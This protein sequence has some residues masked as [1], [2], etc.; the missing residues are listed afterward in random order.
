MSQEPNPNIMHPSWF[1]K[2][3]AGFDSSM[4][5]AMAKVLG[6]VGFIWFCL[7]LDAVGF[8]AL[9]QQTVQALHTH[10]G[11]MV[12]I[13]LWVAFVAQAFIQLVALPV[14]QNYQNRQEAADAAKAEA[15]HRALTYL[16]NLQDAQ[17]T[18]L[19]L[20]TKILNA[21]AGDKETN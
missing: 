10:Q 12:V 8:V 16:A 11:L 19:Q 14:L 18:E 9:I 13:S 1:R 20:Q 2:N 21:L 6:S 4:V 3:V 7:A 17:M 5:N 15:D